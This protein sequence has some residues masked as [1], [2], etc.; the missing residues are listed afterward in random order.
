[1]R[2][3]STPAAQPVSSPSLSLPRQQPTPRPSSPRAPACFR[4][5]VARAPTDRADPLV[6]P[7]PRLLRALTGHA[8][9]PLLR[10]SLACPW[11]TP[12]PQGPLPAPPE[13]RPPSRNLATRAWVHARPLRDPPRPAENCGRYPRRDHAGHARPGSSAPPPLNT[14]RDPLRSHLTPQRRTTLA[15]ALPLLGAE[16]RR[17]LHA[18]EPLR[19]LNPTP[20]VMFW[21]L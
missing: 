17:D 1:M 9:A 8:R 15:A 6:I 14:A 18:G 3:T 16:R 12:P 11:A 2:P 7:V 20:P 10:R 19:R 5:H 21:P 13:R 4:K